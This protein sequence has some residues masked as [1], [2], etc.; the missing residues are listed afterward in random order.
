MYRTSLRMTLV[1]VL[2]GV[3]TFARAEDKTI[4]VTDPSRSI[5]ED[6][7]SLAGQFERL[8]RED[9]RRLDTIDEYASS[10][11]CRAVFL[12][13]YFGSL[14]TVAKRLQGGIHHIGQIHLLDS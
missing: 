10:E 3:C 13:R 9:S 11:E 6:A 8:K 1:L 5:E 7:R 2:V 14:E 12:Q 4:H